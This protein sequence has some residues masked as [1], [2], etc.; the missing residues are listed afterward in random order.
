[1][2]SKQKNLDRQLNFYL[3]QKS[4]IQASMSIIKCTESRIIIYSNFIL[5]LGQNCSVS[6]T[7]LYLSQNTMAPIN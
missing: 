4:T 5:I 2:F 3:K 1:M 6:R 7:L